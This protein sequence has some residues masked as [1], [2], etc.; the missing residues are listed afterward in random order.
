[1]SYV[2]ASEVDCLFDLQALHEPSA[3]KPELFTVAIW[4]KCSIYLVSARK[5]ALI[6]PSHTDPKNR[7]G[8]KY[9]LDDS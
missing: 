7:A 9:K 2:S 8:T 6:S 4:V 3:L 5:L 1:M